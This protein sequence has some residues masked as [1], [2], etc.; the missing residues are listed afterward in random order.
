MILRS[1]AVG[2]SFSFSCG[3]E[4]VGGRGGGEQNDRSILS[5]LG[6]PFAHVVR[7]YIYT[8]ILLS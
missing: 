1:I 2:K 5:L 4:N 7:L 8:P 6:S 3:Q